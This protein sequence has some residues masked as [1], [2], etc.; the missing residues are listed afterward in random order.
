[1]HFLQYYYKYYN[2]V[3]NSN[4]YHIMYAI[5]CQLFY[6]HPCCGSHFFLYIIQKKIPHTGHFIFRPV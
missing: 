4:W 3:T 1:M 2:F 5:F 6:L